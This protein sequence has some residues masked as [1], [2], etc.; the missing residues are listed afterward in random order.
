MLSESWLVQRLETP[1]RGFGPLGVD[2]PFSF[3]GGYKNGGLSDDAMALLRDIFSFDYMGAAEFEFGAVP[4]ALQGIAACA[5]RD[6]LG[7]WTTEVDGH[8]IY[9]IAPDDLQQQIDERIAAFANDYGAN[10][11]RLKEPTRLYGVLHNEPYT[12]RLGGW[13]ELD[14]RFMF[15]T[16]RE[17]A[18]KTAALFGIEAFADDSE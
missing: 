18:H 9:V 4:E 13:L 14:N 6:K 15:F 8:T 2:N 17:M 12:D 11:Y 16:N 5:G 3:G 1:S 10:Y 7:A